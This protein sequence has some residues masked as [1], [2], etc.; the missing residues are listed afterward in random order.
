M[1]IKN[2]ESIGN[3]LATRT[4]MINQDILPDAVIFT[5]LLPQ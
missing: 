4:K 3:T 2:N 1:R 5:P